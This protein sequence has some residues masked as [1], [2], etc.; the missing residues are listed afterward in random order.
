[1][2]ALHFHYCPERFTNCRSIWQGYRVEPLYEQHVQ[3]RKLYKTF[4]RTA[5]VHGMPRYAQP[6]TT[7]TTSTSSGTLVA[8]P[9]CPEHIVP[10]ISYKS[11]PIVTQSSFQ[12]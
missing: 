8:T 5:V 11:R 9:R 4:E 1:M 6:S 2:P 12:Y 10:S 7:I 3:L